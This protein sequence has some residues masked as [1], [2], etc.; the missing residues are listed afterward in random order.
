MW[1]CWG[2][3]SS[4]FF[5]LWVFRN[6]IPTKIIQLFF[7]L[8]EKHSLYRK[9]LKDDSEHEY[10][11]IK[12]HSAFRNHMW[13][14]FHWEGYSL[15]RLQKRVVHRMM[16]PSLTLFCLKSL[17][18]LSCSPFLKIVLQRVEEEGLFGLVLCVWTHPG[19]RQRLLPFFHLRRLVVQ[20][21]KD[22]VWDLKML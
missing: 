1:N 2:L 16:K 19:K 21:Q 22:E 6:L 12:R 8:R 10:I 13:S 20:V 15:Y 11:I 5:L 18:R 14:E 4:L 9:F 7:F 3:P 17:W